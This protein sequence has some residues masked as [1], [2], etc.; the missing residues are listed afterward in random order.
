MTG[1]PTCN[2]LDRYRRRAA[3]VLLCLLAAQL[4]LVRTARSAQPQDIGRIERSDTHK[5]ESEARSQPKAPPLRVVFDPRVEL[6]SIIFRLAGNSE[7][8]KGQVEAY[9]ND[10]EEHFG[11]FRDHPAV[12]LAR[13]LRGTRGVSYDAVMSMA[14]H[15]TDPYRLEEKVPF[16]PWPEDLDARWTPKG[17]REFLAHARQFVQDTSFREFIDKHGPLYETTRSRLEAVLDEHFHLEW[18]PEFF[19]ER[20]KASFTATFGL[21]CGGNC[22]GPRCLTGDGQAELFSILGVWKTDD[23]GAPQFDPGVVRTVVHEFCHSYANSIVDR[24]EADFKPAGQRIYPHVESAMKRQGYGNWKTIMYESLVRACTVRYVRQCSGPLAAWWAIQQ[25]EK[26]HFAWMGELAGLL[27]E[28]EAERDRYPTLD[29]FAPR[30]VAF[31]NDYAE[32]YAEKQAALEA[33]RPKVVSMT[34]ANG[35]SEVDP[36]L[37]AI[38]VV[39]DR[40]MQDGSWSVVGG[41]PHFPEVRGRP[42]YDSAGTT[43]TLPV[44]LKPDWSYEF[45]LN[46]DRFTNFRSREGVPLAPV[47]VSFKTG[48]RPSPVR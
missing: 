6:M 44:R 13:K 35:A 23:Q 18:F 5:E 34:P 7:Y 38:Q 14:V 17:A 29:A 9:T 12:K 2:L 1:K 22:Y 31:F 24:H 10:V 36:E 4:N 8:N 30:I 3:S 28:Y 40:P 25:E 21:L 48:K 19:G 16:D 27:G 39:F 46:S 33:K 42:S 26:R 15:V 37:A 47:T 11:G 20:P 45:M 32:T 41:G 43:F